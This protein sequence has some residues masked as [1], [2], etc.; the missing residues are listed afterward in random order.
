MKADTYTCLS[1]HH[2]YL[3]PILFGF[4]AHTITLREDKNT[5]AKPLKWVFYPEPTFDKE[6]QELVP[7]LRAPAIPFMKPHHYNIA[8]LQWGLQNQ[9]QHH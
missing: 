8:K 7:Y 1:K 4:W 5:Q 3:K 2:E 6:L 9:P